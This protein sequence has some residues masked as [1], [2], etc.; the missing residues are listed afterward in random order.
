[1]ILDITKINILRSLRVMIACKKPKRLS[2]SFGK[3][4]GIGKEVVEIWV[5]RSRLLA[6]IFQFFPPVFDS[7]VHVADRRH[8][9]SRYFAGHF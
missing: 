8:I 2:F 1:M 4:S 3:C 7:I 6:S 9:Y 5:L